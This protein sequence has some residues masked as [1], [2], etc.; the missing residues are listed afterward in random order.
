MKLNLPDENSP[1]QALVTFR[2]R[3]AGDKASPASILPLDEEDATSKH[4]S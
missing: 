1:L 2:K 3:E 4:M